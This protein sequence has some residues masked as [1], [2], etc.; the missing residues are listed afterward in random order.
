MPEQGTD[1]LDRIRGRLEELSPND[2]RVADA[3]LRAEVLVAERLGGETYFH[4]RLAGRS[5]IA[6]VTGDSRV[7]IGDAVGL[8]F[9]PALAHAFV[10]DGRRL[11]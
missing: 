1:P 4:L 3:V 7:A 8:A 10:P 2:Q 9:D 5:A 11:V 6:R